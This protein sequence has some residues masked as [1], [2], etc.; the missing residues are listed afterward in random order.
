MR[1]K[2]TSI[3]MSAMLI[4]SLLGFNNFTAKAD[5]KAQVTAQSSVGI[6]Q[7]IFL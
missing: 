7:I 5:T 6:I 4:T 1:K 3:I 2:I